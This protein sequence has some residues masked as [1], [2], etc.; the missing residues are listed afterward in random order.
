MNSERF[1]SNNKNII[2]EKYGR[3]EFRS[4]LDVRD[5]NIAHEPIPYVAAMCNGNGMKYSNS[6]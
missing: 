2:E 4:A 6:K 3:E 5:A 1:F